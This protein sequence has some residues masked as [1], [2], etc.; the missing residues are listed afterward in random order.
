MKQGVKNRNKEI[1]QILVDSD[2]QSHFNIKFLL[3][4]IQT[5]NFAIWSKIADFEFIVEMSRESSEVY[6]DVHGIDSSNDL[7]GIETY[8]SIIEDPSND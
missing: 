3:L 8:Y 5:H 7:T 4:Y 1:K 2:D 6:F